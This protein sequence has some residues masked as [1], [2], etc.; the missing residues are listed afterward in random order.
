MREVIAKEK[1]NGWRNR[2]WPT[3][4]H[5]MAYLF[6]LPLLLSPQSLPVL[7]QAAR[8][9]SQRAAIALRGGQLPTQSRVLP[10]EARHLRHLLCQARL[11]VLHFLRPLLLKGK[12][13]T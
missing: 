9:R 12:E 10:L 7:A 1:V 11:K 13:F 2:K 4:T 5:Y 6:L 8:V 3:F